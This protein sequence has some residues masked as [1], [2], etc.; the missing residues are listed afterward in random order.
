MTCITTLATLLKNQECNSFGNNL[1]FLELHTFHLFDSDHLCEQQAPA[2]G[3]SRQETMF[4]FLAKEY[5]STVNT[6]A[7]YLPEVTTKDRALKRIQ[8]SEAINTL[9]SLPFEAGGNDLI[10][11]SSFKRQLFHR[12]FLFVCLASKQQRRHLK[13]ILYA[14]SQL[15]LL[16]FPVF[17]DF[18]RLVTNWSILNSN[19][20]LP[21]HTQI[22]FWDPQIYYHT[23]VKIFSLSATTAMESFF[24]FF[25]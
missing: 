22:H 6:T 4:T 5:W 21:P 10:L 18:S 9:S 17:S 8:E 3:R 25:K 2:W 20:S 19:F 16:A 15:P 1:G 12:A 13:T 23:L 14:H 7:A 11:M 24:F